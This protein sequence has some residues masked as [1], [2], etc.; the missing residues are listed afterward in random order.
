MNVVES[1]LGTIDLLRKTALS[2]ERQNLSC[3][4]SH[5]MA[6]VGDHT[7]LLANPGETS[8]L[9]ERSW[10]PQRTRRTKKP[11]LVT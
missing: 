1:W 7:C 9:P 8:S 2:A 6:A 5:N 10:L 11:Y 3:A 4:A